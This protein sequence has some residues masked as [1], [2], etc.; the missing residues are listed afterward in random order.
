MSDKWYVSVQVEETN[1][2]KRKMVRAVSVIKK[3]AEEYAA[4]LITQ[5]A[6]GEFFDRVKK[7]TFERGARVFLEH[8]KDR[9][10]EGKMGARTCEFY[11]GRVSANLIPA[12]RDIEMTRLTAELIE[13]YKRRRMSEVKPATINREL[14]TLKR[15]CVVLMAKGLVKSNPSQS[16]EMLRENN[17]RD[18]YL[19]EAEISALLRECEQLP[20]LQMVVMIALNTGLRLD[21]CLTLKWN[22][23]D[24]KRNQITKVV[25]GGKTVFIP[26]N[27]ELK[28]ALLARRGEVP[29]INGYV[30]PSP[31]RRMAV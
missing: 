13:Q 20:R 4:K 3:T 30:T 25:K 15:M 14:A 10:A 1:G 19:N 2:Q 21:G 8:C 31:K 7:L 9:V 12:F 18:R 26:I 29:R 22:E 6:E 23:I 17:K 5:R 11:E 24:F 27:N 28:A 16:V